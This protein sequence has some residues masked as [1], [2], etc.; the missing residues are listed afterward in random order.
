[1]IF[2]L[3]IVTLYIS[4]HKTIGLLIGYLFVLIIGVLD[5]LTGYKLGFSIF[6]LIPIVLIV[7]CFSLNWGII[8]SFVSTVVWAIADIAARGEDPE[9]FIMV[10][11]AAIRMGFF[12]TVTAILVNL[13]Q[14][15]EREKA[16]ARTD[17]LTGVAN[18]QSF[19]ETFNKE[20]NRSKRYG[21]PFT[22][23]YLDCDEFKAINDSLGHEAGNQVLKEVAA[24]MVK[25]IRPNDKVGRLGGDEF[26]VLM[27]ETGVAESKNAVKRLERELLKAMKLNNWGVTF[28]IGAASSIA[29]I[30]S[31]SEIISHVDK[32]MYSAKN[33]GKNQIVYGEKSK[34]K[35]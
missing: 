35:A 17:F 21:R 10:W 32:L 6:Y 15:L 23:V 8:I 9:P 24:T 20:L 16:L 12:I 25:A 3:Q 33:N 14:S 22:L 4:K 29:P 2:I 13:K 27:P 5:Y 18:N 31:A 19:M 30:Q 26:L 7:W 34:D 28:S 1:M 11:N